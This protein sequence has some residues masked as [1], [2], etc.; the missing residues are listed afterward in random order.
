MSTYSNHYANYRNER[1]TLISEI[2]RGEVIYSTVQYD[3]KRG[4]YFKYEITDNAILIVKDKEE[5]Y[6]IT[7]FIARPSRLRR[8]WADC[9]QEIIMK[10]VEH[11]RAQMFI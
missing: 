11:T 6:I 8:Y 2:G 9:P 4:R 5:D 10:A 3:E 1:N 7:E